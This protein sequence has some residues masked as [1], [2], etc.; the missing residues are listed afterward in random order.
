MQKIFLTFTLLI[1]LFSIQWL[2]A[3]D[4]RNKQGQRIRYEYKKYEKF[5]FDDLV[6][7]GDTGNPGDISLTSRYQKKFKNK[8]PYRTNFIPEMAKAAER[9]R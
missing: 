8:L 3:Q 6:I 2:K 1:A 4:T 9:V 7:E 5:D